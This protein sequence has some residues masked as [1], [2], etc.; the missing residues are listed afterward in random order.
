M[1]LLDAY[2]DELA[3]LAAVAPAT[4]AVMVAGKSLGRGASK[5]QAQQLAV[6]AGALRAQRLKALGKNPPIGVR[7]IRMGNRAAPPGYQPAKPHSI[8]AQGQLRAINQ[9]FGMR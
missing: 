8:K 3:K 7:D 9:A 4:H 1:N 5:P 6:N 2:Y